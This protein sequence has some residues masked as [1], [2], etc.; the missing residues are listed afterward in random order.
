MVQAS[1]SVSYSTTSS[2]AL[3]FD[4]H[5]SH[6]T[7][8]VINKAAE[9]GIII[10]CLPLHSTHLA[11]PINKG[12][13]SILKRY[14]LEK[15]HNYLS[16]IPGNVITMFT[17]CQVFR[18]AWTQSMTMENVISGFLTTGV[19]P[20]NK[21]AVFIKTPV[22]S[23]MA[24]LEAKK[25]HYLPLYSPSLSRHTSPVH[26]TS[27]T[28]EEILRFQRCY[29]EG[30]DLETDVRYNK[31][32]EM[33]HPQGTPQPSSPHF[34]ELFPFSVSCS[35]D[36]SR[37]EEEKCHGSQSCQLTSVTTLSKFLNEMPNTKVPRK[38]AKTSARVLTSNENHKMLEE[39]ERKKKEALEE[40]E[41]KKMCPIRKK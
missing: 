14:W 8:S 23:R 15:C 5:S 40:K 1:F 7:P 2:I 17:F 16:S 30:Y 13:F 26:N 27:F 34:E 39:K 41:K 22:K 4:G 20:I 11:Q 3:L 6:N 36:T 19:Y 37:P 18:R 21:A 28:T 24:N 31:W 25:I 32:V 29:E 38:E 10:F 33:Y 35:P 12:C 9:E